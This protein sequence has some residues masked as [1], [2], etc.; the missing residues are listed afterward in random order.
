L[1]DAGQSVLLAYA[2]SVVIRLLGQ[3]SPGADITVDGSASAAMQ[4]ASVAR[5]QWSVVS[6]AVASLQNA[7][8]PVLK[9]KLASGAQQYVLKLQV[10]DNLGAVG[11]DTIAFVTTAPI[12]SGGGGGA[13][14][15]LWGVGLWLILIVVW[16][17]KH[18]ETA[19]SPR[20]CCVSSYK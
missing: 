15:W 13:M 11:E 1:L 3:P 7:N 8:S 19:S 16:A 4:G 5:Y 20:I 6:G 14:P 10:T 2:P 17:Q 18:K 12:D 9:L